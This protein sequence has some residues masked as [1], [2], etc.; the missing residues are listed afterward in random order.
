MKLKNWLLLLPAVL[1]TDIAIAQN[2]TLPKALTPQQ[3]LGVLIDSTKSS[4]VEVFSNQFKGKRVFEGRRT[5]ENGDEI[6]VRIVVDSV[7]SEIGIYPKDAECNCFH[8]DDRGQVTQTHTSVKL[9]SLGAVKNGAEQVF[10]NSRGRIEK[11]FT[12][13]LAAAQA[14]WKAYLDGVLFNKQGDRFR[15]AIRYKK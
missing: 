11:G 4:L 7:L 5:L 14:C 3:E 1:A 6:S 10:E 13:E 15:S 12:D 8:M 9:G 2:D